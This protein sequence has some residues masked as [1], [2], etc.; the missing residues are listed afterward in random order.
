MDTD[1][2]ITIDTQWID[3]FEMY[4]TFKE[5]PVRN[6]KITYCYIDD[7]NNIY[8]IK[9]NNINIEQSILQQGKLLYLIKKNAVFS[10]QKHKLLSLLK[11]NLGFN[12]LNINNI[13]TQ[14]EHI[15]ITNVED[16][17]FRELF[18]L[19]EI[20]WDNTSDIFSDMNEL[21]IFYKSKKTTLNTTKR[22]SINTNIRKKRNKKTRKNKI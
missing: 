10:K 11:F 21:F 22:V 5:E 9:R 20:V 19:N 12:G 3:D 7:E 2:D 17:Y 1:N 8:H 4:E 16:G 14:L 18:R 6:I 13:L 15:N